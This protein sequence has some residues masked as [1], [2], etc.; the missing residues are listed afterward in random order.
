MWQKH[1]QPSELDNM[2]YWEFEEYIKLMNDRNKE[3]N[4]QSKQQEEDYKT[5]IPKTPKLPN[6]NIPNFR[7]PKF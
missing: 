5:Q 2:S 1:I 6:Y 7:P 3:D 4:K